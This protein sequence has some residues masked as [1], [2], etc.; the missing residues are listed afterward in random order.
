MYGMTYLSILKTVISGP[1]KLF[2]SML[3][4]ITHHLI[5]SIVKSNTAIS[6]KI[7]NLQAGFTQN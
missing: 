3:K 6:V 5:K 4:I 7:V 2:L 1:S